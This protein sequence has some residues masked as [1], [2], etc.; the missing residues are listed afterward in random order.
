MFP[1]QS[2]IMLVHQYLCIYQVM[3][4]GIIHGSLGQR[5]ALPFQLPGKNRH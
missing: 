5:K 4:S 1:N 2:G 3:Y